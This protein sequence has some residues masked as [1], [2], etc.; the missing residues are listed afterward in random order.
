MSEAKQK[1]TNIV[2]LDAYKKELEI[3]LKDNKELLVNL[4]ENKQQLFKDNFLEL[5]TNKF[6][7]EGIKDKKLIL[8]LAID[9]T[10]QGID[11]NPHSKQVSIVPYAIGKNSN[12]KV[13]QAIIHLKGKQEEYFQ[14]G[15]LLKVIKVWKLDNGEVKREDEMSYLELSQIKETDEKF[16]QEHFVGWVVVLED[17]KKE[18]PKQEKFVSYGYAKSVSK[19][20]QV[21]TENELEGLIHSA[22]RHAERYF[23]IPQA[24]K[25]KFLEALENANMKI[26]EE[27]NIKEVEIIDKEVDYKKLLSNEMSKLGLNTSELKKMFADYLKDNGINVFTQ[28]G[29]KEA[30]EHKD[31]LINLYKSFEEEMQNQLILQTE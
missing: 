14:S 26:L 2:S 6:L 11:I 4:P 7:M 18:L 16:R 25:S 27:E 31:K 12:Y 17:L 5:Y 10:K 23:V 13:P 24:R 1:N 22:V 28:E 8:K 30:L 15:F 20:K 29:A 19:N 3:T 21:P 9:L